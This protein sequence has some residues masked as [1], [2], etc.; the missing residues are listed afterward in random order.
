PHA[1]APLGPLR[2]G[3]VLGSM[4]RHLGL[5]SRF[6]P[7]LCACSHAVDSDIAWSANHAADR[8]NS[9]HAVLRFAY[10]S[11]VRDDGAALRYLRL[12]GGVAVLPRLD[13]D[14]RC[15]SSRRR[16]SLQLQLFAVTGLE[17]DLFC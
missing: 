10:P 12:A 15:S 13:G 2:V 5:G 16:T 8:G 1:S 14:R 3:I 4:V 17:H 7:A 11:V 6:G 9:F